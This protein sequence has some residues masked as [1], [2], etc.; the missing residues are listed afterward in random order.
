MFEFAFELWSI[1][2]ISQLQILEI[3][4]IVQPHDLLELILTQVQIREIS[5]LSDALHALQ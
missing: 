3:I 2:V 5:H 1:G 4:K